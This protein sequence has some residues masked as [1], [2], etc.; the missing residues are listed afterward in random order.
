[1]DEPPLDRRPD[2]DACLNPRAESRRPAQVLVHIERVPTRLSTPPALGPRLTVVR[3]RHDPNVVTLDLDL[4]VI[5]LRVEQEDPSWP[6]DDV[7]DVETTLAQV[8]SH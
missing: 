3:G 2:D 7:V 8:M 4:A 6:D 5:V 1:M